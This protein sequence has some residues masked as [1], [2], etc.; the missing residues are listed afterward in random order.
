[1][2]FRSLSFFLD[3]DGDRQ[4]C[5]PF[6]SD[7]LEIKRTLQ[8]NEYFYLSELS[9]NVKFKREDFRRINSAPFAAKFTFECNVNGFNKYTGTFSK[10]DCKFNLNE[11]EAD[12][13]LK[14]KDI[15]YEVLDNTDKEFDVPRMGA[16][17]VNLII[18]EK[19]VIQIYFLNSPVIATIR[20]GLS[21]NSTVANGTGYGNTNDLTGAF[22]FSSVAPAIYIPGDAT[23]L[24]P[25]VSGFYT[26][27][28][29]YEFVRIDNVYKLERL[30]VGPGANDSAYN[31]VI[32]RVSDNIIEYQGPFDSG[33]FDFGHGGPRPILETPN[34]LHRCSFYIFK[35]FIRLLSNAASY[36]DGSGGTI[37]GQAI[38]ANDITGST[39]YEYIYPFN[40]TGLDR[41]FVISD[42]TQTT[43]NEFKPIPDYA[44]NNSGLYYL[45]PSDSLGE[46]VIPLA[47]SDWNEVSIWFRYLPEI[48]TF[49][50]LL[51]EEKKI[52]GAGFRVDQVVQTALSNFGSTIT[53]DQ[54]PQYSRIFNEDIWDPD[55]L[56]QGSLANIFSGEGYQIIVPKS[57]ILT[58]NFTEADTSEKLTLGDILNMWRMAWNAY[59]YVDG[60]S[61]LR[62]ENVLYFTRGRAYPDETPAINIGFDLTGKLE[63]KHELPWAYWANNYEYEKDQ[64]PEQI[65]F[66]WA[67][68]SSRFFDG[69]P[70]KLIADWNEKGNVLDLSTGKFSV[71]I[72]FAAVVPDLFS[73]EGFF[74]LQCDRVVEDGIVFYKPQESPLPQGNTNYPNA[75]VTN[76]NM[77]FPRIQRAYY[78]YDASGE[79]LETTGV[80]LQPA[81]TRKRTKVQDISI[82][83]DLNALDLDGQLGTTNLGTGTIKEITEDL[84]Y[85]TLKLKIIHETN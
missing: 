4:T 19:P 21:V 54:D 73:P 74:W 63:P 30:V 6:Y 20:S 50:E 68:R 56:G 25:D 60:Q 24:D 53:Y 2:P 55:F 9:G 57:N 43:P 28:N 42:L 32:R 16:P 79:Q 29:T 59:W 11:E 64:L 48:N 81:R 35:A 66:K 34:T 70:L 76:G 40:T 26:E 51:W 5:I 10:T 83:Q 82:Y 65:Q 72:E 85:G 13:K 80:P 8:D 41:P 71:D 36:P 17:A 14:A 52:F 47:E 78:S 58:L 67:D 49:S 38:A 18:T 27:T 1:M 69:D 3:I 39:N 12:V 45:N 61:R 7:G 84:E 46:N 37:N 22:G 44:A 23:L 75:R 33:A 31:W 77:N 62:V 15:H